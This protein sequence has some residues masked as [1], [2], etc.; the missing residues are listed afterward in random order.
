[1]RFLDKTVIRHHVKWMLLDAIGQPFLP[2][3][4]ENTGSIPVGRAS[5][6]TSSA[7]FHWGSGPITP[8]PI[9]DPF[10]TNAADPAGASPPGR[11]LCRRMCLTLTLWR[12]WEL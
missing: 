12:S 9:Q 3:H 10:P 2:F 6:I 5:K 8:A 4:G 7:R 11:S 1:M